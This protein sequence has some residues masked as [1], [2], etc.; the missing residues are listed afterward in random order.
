MACTSKTIRNFVAKT[1]WKASYI[2]AINLVE[3]RKSIF[4]NHWFQ[5]KIREMPDFKILQFTLD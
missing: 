5:Q 3:R 4:Q 2:S 1:Y